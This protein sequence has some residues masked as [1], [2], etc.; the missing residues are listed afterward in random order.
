MVH[1]VEKLSLFV[2]AKVALV[3]EL[4]V[5]RACLGAGREN[6]QRQERNA[7]ILRFAQDDDLFA[8]PKPLKGDVEQ[9]SRQTE[10]PG[11]RI[12]PPSWVR[13]AMMVDHQVVSSSS[14]RVRS[15][16]WKTHLSRRA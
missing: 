11:A 10:A 14:R 6:R 7:G 3:L 13:V 5:S 2:V 4:Y 1:G 12:V 8:K 16:D 15:L 9:Q